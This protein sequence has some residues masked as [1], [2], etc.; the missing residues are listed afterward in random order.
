MRLRRTLAPLL[1]LLVLGQARAADADADAEAAD[2]RTLH[3][4]EMPTDGPGL[5]EFF[6]KRTLLETDRL[7]V[8]AL[9]RKLGDDDFVVR[10]QATAALRALGPAAGPQLREAL[11]DP[12]LEIF[13]RA[14]RCLASLDQSG[15]PAALGAAVRVLGRLKPPG[16]VETLL[17]SL[18]SFE[19]AEVVDD[20]C[21]ALAA[22]AVHGGK[23][24]PALIVALADHSP[25]RRAAAGEALCRGGGADLRPS[26]ARL[27][28]DPDATVRQRVAM[29]LLDAH[30]KEAVPALI[31]LLGETAKERSGPLEEALR[32]VAGEQAPALSPGDDEDSR[33]KCRDAWE[34]WWKEHGAALDLSKIDL[35]MRRL[36]YLVVAEM[37]LRTT[38]SRI[39]EYDAAGKERWQIGGLRYAIDV[40]MIGTDRVLIA[41]YITHVVTE[42]NLKGE[43]LRD[44]RANGLLL[45][46]RRLTNGDTFVVTRNSLVELDKDFKEISSI[47]RPNDVCSAAKFRDGT[48]ALLTNGGTVIHLDETGKELKSLPLNAPVLAVGSNIDALPNG[49][50]IVPLYSSNKVVELDG[51]GKTVWEV[52]TT[53]PTSVV[54][55]PNGHTLIASRLAQTVLELD[56]AG[57]EI[58]NMKVEGRPF[59]VGQR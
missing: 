49:H 59:R 51:D 10:E 57:R 41:E 18:P 3:V 24:D 42:R 1:V 9:I 29:A 15:K 13:M 40:Q 4:A 33:H 45:G 26:V 27:L 6:R 16:T 56:H 22:A 52:A 46:A 2:E 12:D 8:Q 47:Q 50:V 30:D 35:S 31:S 23:V 48:I 55:L 43:V 21:Q 34:D 7:H 17:A 20:A 11:R 58:R 54:R 36:G 53:Q 5:L 14:Q 37:E 28:Q 39:V 19:D 32:L 25:V 38:N 44:Y